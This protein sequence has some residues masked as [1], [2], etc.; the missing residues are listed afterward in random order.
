MLRIKAQIANLLTSSLM[1]ILRYHPIAKFVLV[2]YRYHIAYLILRRL[3]TI[4]NLHYLGLLG[5]LLL[6]TIS[7]YQTGFTL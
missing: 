4:T 3:T 2:V 1:V 6:S 5:A 7:F